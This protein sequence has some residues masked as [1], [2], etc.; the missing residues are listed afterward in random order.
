MSCANSERF[1]VDFS[2][3]L[4]PPSHGLGGENLGWYGCIVHFVR[5]QRNILVGTAT[6]KLIL[7]L[8]RCVLACCLSQRPTTSTTKSTTTNRSRGHKKINNKR[9]EKTQ[10]ALPLL[11]CRVMN[12]PTIITMPPLMDGPSKKM[13]KIT[14]DYVK[15]LKK[16]LVFASGAAV[17]ETAFT[18]LTDIEKKIEVEYRQ[19]IEKFSFDDIDHIERFGP[20]PAGFNRDLALADLLKDDNG[21]KLYR[22]FKALK[23]QFRTTWTKHVVHKSGDNDTDMIDRVCRHV[24]AERRQ[25]EAKKKKLMCTDVPSDC[26]ASFV[27]LEKATFAAFWDHPILKRAKSS[28]EADDSD[29]RTPHSE[30]IVGSVMNRAEQRALKKQKTSSS[31]SSNNNNNELMQRKM[32]IEEEHLAV[33]KIQ[34]EQMQIQKKINVATLFKDS[35][36]ALYQKLIMKLLDKEDIDEMDGNN[37]N[38]NKDNNNNNN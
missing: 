10:Q 1:G 11:L 28:L 24:W 19:R 32:K 33:A 30:T 38:N 34:A 37:N 12:P 20:L 22:A 5:V 26:P 6:D 15:P 2:P 7:I 4:C 3:K 13:S 18:T 25:A 36:P 9:I 23:S 17:C 31:S 29:E 21:P 14:L 16:F 8:A 35:H 27:P